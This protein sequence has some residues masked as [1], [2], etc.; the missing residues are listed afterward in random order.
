LR[1]I[2]TYI[3][4]AFLLSSCSGLKY[5]PATEKL[6]TGATINI[7]GKE[8]IAG[9]GSVK[10]SLNEV[11]AKPNT[12]FL[13]MRFGLWFY[14]VTGKPKRPKG[15]RAWIKAKFGEPPV[16]L[17]SVDTALVTKAINARLYNSGFLD[18]YNTFEIKDG[19][20]G[21]TAAI[22]YHVILKQPYTI[23]EISFPPDSTP[24]TAEIAKVQPQTLIHK[25][26][27][28][29]LD[30]LLSERKRIDTHLKHH[31]YYYFNA[32]Y[33]LYAMDTGVGSRQICLRGMIKK[34]TPEKARNIYT[35]ESVNVYP[36]YKLGKP[37]ADTPAVI[38]DSAYY[39]NVTNY[40]RPKAVMNDIFFRPGHIYDSRIYNL[41]LSRL[42]GLGVFKFINVD[43]R[44]MDSVAL[45]RLLMKVLLMP[46]QKK[47]VRVEFDVATKSNNFTGPSLTLSLRNRNAFKGEELIIYKLSTSFETEFS[48]QYK[49]LFTYEIDPGIEFNIPRFLSLIPFHVNGNYVPH[50]LIDLDYSYQ[51]RVG[52]FDLN[53][54]KASFGY[55][56]KTSP[57]I[58]HTFK[59]FN[60]AYYN[61][62][63]RTAAFDTIVDQ[64]ILL[65][66]R[67]ENQF[68]AG[69]TYS[70]LYNEQVK[71]G[72]KN[73]FYF[74]FNADLSGNLLSLLYHAATGHAPNDSSTIFGV[75]FAQ[76]TR[77]DIEIRDYYHIAK[78]MIAFRAIAGW[79]IGYGSSSALP[80]E[81]QFFSGGA[82]SVRGFP[83]YSLGPGTY[84]PTE[85]N[86]FYL[87]QG[88]EIKLEANAEYRFPIIS[89][90]KGALF[91]DAGNTWLNRPNIDAPGGAWQ[92]STFYKE[93]AMSTGAGLRVDLNF[94]VIRLDVG[95]PIRRPGLPNPWVLQ[96]TDFNS[97]E[98]NFAFGYPF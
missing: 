86:I 90:L 42:N 67:F 38:V 21:K 26:D 46:L 15:A 88:G 94:F 41:S 97:L 12:A 6:Y 57:L 59:P 16:Y 51:S 34:T 9:K 85:S 92:G 7:T 48:G 47:S 5:V 96:T 72:K 17:S 71:V 40:I 31:G 13:G 93:I 98:F 49:G 63:K 27:R 84:V 56:W 95:I 37:T 18:S 32:G 73:Q 70:F 69:M 28:Y 80:Y 43:I 74:N 24:L 52:Y 20:H 8:K 29:S 64:N 30:A 11:K 79:G 35:I 61:I 23:K 39:H 87:Q 83:A 68:I 50:T 33:I 25:G 36:D 60:V 91:V 77:L 10:S 78:S 89:Y 1:R 82:Y 19:H 65:E 62:Y 44:D 75:N 53:S 14:N 4:I 3:T 2:F 81:K 76:Y 45:H 22:T 55:E 58:S 54:F 66:R